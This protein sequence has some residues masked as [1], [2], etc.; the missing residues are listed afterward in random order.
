MLRKASSVLVKSDY[1]TSLSPQSVFVN[2]QS[3]KFHF[4]VPQFG[5]VSQ[6]FINV[7]F[8]TEPQPLLQVNADQISS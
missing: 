1:L 8:F 3:D 5:D 2:Q 4:C 6:I 7:Y